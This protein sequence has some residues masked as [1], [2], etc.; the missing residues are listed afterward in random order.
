MIENNRKKYA[1]EEK[2]NVDNTPISR[3][4]AEKINSCICWQTTN[5]IL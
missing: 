2:K 4:K 3:I 1:Y 5:H